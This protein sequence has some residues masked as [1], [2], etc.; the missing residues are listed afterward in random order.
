M[1]EPASAPALEREGKIHEPA[2]GQKRAS[3]KLEKLNQAKEK[4]EIIQR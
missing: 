4:I 2:G 3:G 1:G